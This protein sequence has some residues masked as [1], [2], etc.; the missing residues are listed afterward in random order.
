MNLLVIVLQSSI[1]TAGVKVNGDQASQ[2]ASHVR[3]QSTSVIHL[4]DASCRGSAVLMDILGM[5]FLY[6]DGCW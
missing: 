5:F 4:S 2:E 3:P 1:K 6:D